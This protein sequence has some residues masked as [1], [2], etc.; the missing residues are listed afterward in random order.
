MRRNPYP[1]W[2]KIFKPLP[3][4][5]QNFGQNS[6]PYWHKTQQNSTQIILVCSAEFFAILGRNLTYY[7]LLH[8]FWHKHWKKSYPLWHTLCVKNPTLIGTLLENPTLSGTEMCQKGTLAVL[9]YA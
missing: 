4:L 6:Y 7:R 8:S 1:H 3:L 2:H 9:A 5:A